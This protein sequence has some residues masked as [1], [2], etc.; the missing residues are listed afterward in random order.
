MKNFFPYWV[1]MC[2]IALFTLTLPIAAQNTN[3]T[4]EYKETLK[5]I[6]NLSGASAT[7]DLYPKMISMMKLN[8]PGKD[9]SYW[10]EFAKNWKEKIENRTIEICMPVYEKHLTLEDLKTIAAFYESPVGKKYKETSL[11]VMREAMPLLV[12]ELQTGMFKEVMPEMNKQMGE[13]DRAIK[14]NEQKQNRDRELFA[15]AYVLPEDSIVVAPGKVYKNGMSTAPS[16]YSIER[17]KKDTKVTFMQPIYWDGQWLY[18]SP[19]FKIIDKETGDEY[20]VRGYDGV[21]SMD[22]LLVVNGFNHK[23]IY[24]SLLFPKLKKS[25]KE[26]DILELP[27]EKDKEL[28]PSNDDGKA[29]SYFN[30]KVKDY[31]VSSG[32]KE[33]KV[34][35]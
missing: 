22:R 16:L 33:K 1:M 2:I 11:A 12:Q 30:V 23:Y 14:E 8:A 3:A 17:R 5:K 13:N 20:N 31:Q 25:V 19:G 7:E 6:M 21:A 10:N 9:E 18:F 24:V 27:H 35:F 29:K 15:Q 28:L 32:K 26:V 4:D 34:Y